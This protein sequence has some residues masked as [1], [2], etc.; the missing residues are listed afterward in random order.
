MD[1]TIKGY[2][3]RVLKLFFGLGLGAFGV[4]FTINANFG[5]SPWDVFAQGVAIKATELAGREIMLGT[6][7]QLVGV[8]VLLAVILLKETIGFGTIC[9]I[10]VFGQFLNMYM[11]AGVVPTPEST[12]MRL[13][14]L[15]VGFFIWS[16]GIYVYMSAG[17]G[18]G[19]RDS[20]M[21]ALARR[22]IPVS[23]AKNSIEAVVL[24]IGFLCGGKVG[25][26]TVVAVFIMGYFIKFIFG[27]FK[28]DITTV[29]N[30]S[31]I[32]T[33]R[34]IKKALTKTVSL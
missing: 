5:L 33:I 25:L 17:L 16:F 2:A 20:L 8:V 32:D 7:I 13:I 11:K 3:L 31:I 18:A 30:D 23:L 22:N 28:F 4:A 1:T 6:I 24:A 19:P 14:F 34:N 29:E 9:D 12:P 21:A 10:L 15:F 27:I 26:G